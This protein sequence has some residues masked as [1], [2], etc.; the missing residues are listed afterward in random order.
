MVRKR[1]NPLKRLQTQAE[2]AVHDLALVMSF[3]D[4]YVD[5]LKIKTGKPVRI[6]Q[7]CADA[8]NNMQFNWFI[9]LAVYCIESN[10]KRK[11]ITQ[12]LPMIGRYRHDELTAFL[13]D[14]HQAMQDEAA[15]QNEVVNAGWAAVPVRRMSEEELTAH[16]VALL[17]DEKHWQYKPE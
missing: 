6:G 16:M 10:G 11:L 2:I 4:E 7:A 15:K 17:D 9:I 8:L 1:H 14:A 5:L 13:R 12:P 3:A